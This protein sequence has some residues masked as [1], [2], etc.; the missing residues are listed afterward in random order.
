MAGHSKW[1]N[2]QGRKNAQDAKRGKLFQ[3][4]SREIYV[5]A[6]EG[7]DP[8]M[9]PA[10]RLA[11]D[12]A[13][14][15]NM[16]ND[17]IER[18]IKRASDQGEGDDYKSV[19]YEAYGPNGVGLLIYALTDNANRTSANV[20]AA[21]SRN[22][23]SLGAPGSVA[24][25]FD[26]KGYLAIEREGLDVDEETMLMSVLEAGGEDLLTAPEVYEIFTEPTELAQVRDALETDYELARAELTMVPQ[27]LVPLSEA[28]Q[29]VLD[30]LIDV[31]EDDDDVTEVV[32]NA[33]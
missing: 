8:E 6:K 14:A 16:P 11:M 21:L 10:L 26:R 2:I 23:G 20:K 33:E 29:A 15:A 5:A 3:K 17:N 18:A 27:V 24:F 12:K 30:Q 22:G 31:L 13:K 7:D 4:L 25:Q 1:Q 28:D 9:N 32:T 19:L